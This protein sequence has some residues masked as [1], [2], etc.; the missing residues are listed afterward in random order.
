M[1]VSWVNGPNEASCFL[2]KPLHEKETYV[3]KKN[4]K[5]EWLMV[6][7]CL[8]HSLFGM[9][10]FSDASRLRLYSEYLSLRYQP[11]DS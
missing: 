3:R 11:K 1:L 10:L 9:V 4:Y 5:I 2:I 8:F 7:A 6:I